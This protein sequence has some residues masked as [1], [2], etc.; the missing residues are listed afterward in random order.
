[1]VGVAHSR[2]GT[3]HSLVLCP[4]PY[5]QLHVHSDL[6]GCM[7]FF[8]YTDCQCTTDR[9]TSSTHHIS[10]I[11]PNKFIKVVMN[12]I[13]NKWREFLQLSPVKVVGIPSEGIPSAQ[14]LKVSVVTD[15]QLPDT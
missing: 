3:I 12:S 14:V 8:R 11:T 5:C 7:G 9:N 1:M 2:I 13:H 15:Y 4:V 10:H 6:S